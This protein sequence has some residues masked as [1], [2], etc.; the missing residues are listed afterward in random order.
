MA[1]GVGRGARGAAGIADVVAA[2]EQ[3]RVELLLLADGFDA[4]ERESAIEQA[5]TQSADV[6]WC[7]ATTTSSNT[8]GSEPCSASDG[9]GAAHR[10][11]PE[12]LHASRRGAGGPGRRRHRRPSTGSRARA[13]TTSWWPR[14]TGTRGTTAPSPPRGARGPSPAVQGHVRRR[15]PSCARPSAGRRRDRRGRG[16][17]HRGLLAFP[18]HAL[19]KLLRERGVEH[20]TVVGLA[21]DYCVKN[22]ALDA[23]PSRL[24][25]HRGLHGRAR[26]GRRGRRLRPC[27]G[28]AARGGGERRAVERGGR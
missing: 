28:G 6:W 13:S 3:A 20:V 8:A 24:R 18:T 17:G 25:G 19:G 10:R 4:P 15:A 26:R 27:A 21:T 1:E 12:R 23:L 22:T 11:L 2:L 9:A 7:A 16:P 14:A 5:I